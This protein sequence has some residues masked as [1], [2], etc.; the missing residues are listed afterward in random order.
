MIKLNKEMTNDKFEQLLYRKAK[1]GVNAS[2]QKYLSAINGKK[3]IIM[4]DDINLLDENSSIGRFI[5]SI[6]AQ[7]YYFDHITL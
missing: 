5:R 4:F 1:I 3:L 7:G 6:L 2:K